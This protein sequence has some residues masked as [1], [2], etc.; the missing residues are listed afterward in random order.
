VAKL[1]PGAPVEFTV[2][3]YAGRTFSG[4]VDRINPSAD[5][6][7][8]QVRVYATL[9]NSDQGLVAGLFAEGRI[10]TD[11]RK[12]LLVPLSAV[13][14]RGVTP[15]VL[16][17]RGGRVAQ[18]GVELGVRDPATDQIE[19]RAG[20]QQGDTVLVGAATAIQPGTPVRVVPSDVSGER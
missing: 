20:L 13:D 15:T 6:A 14:Q 17:A 9:P 19:I 12:T 11:H 5:P 1:K 10:G 4:T 7:T 2:S 16:V 3:G 18:Q 8:R